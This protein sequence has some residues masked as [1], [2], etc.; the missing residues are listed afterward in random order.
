M[1]QSSFESNMLFQRIYLCVQRDSL[2]IFI[3]F[4]R[5]NRTNGHKARNYCINTCP[6]I[7]MDK[8]IYKI[9][10]RSLRIQPLSMVVPLPGYASPMRHNDPSSMKRHLHS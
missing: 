9:S 8:E 5:C 2:L 4:V 1:K 7:T 3:G 10:K 6:K